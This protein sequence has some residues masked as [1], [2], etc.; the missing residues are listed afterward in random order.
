MFETNEIKEVL[1]KWFRDEEFG[2]E[3]SDFVEEEY[4]DLLKKALISREDLNFL[5]YD[6]K[7]TLSTDWEGDNYHARRNTFLTDCAD[8][9][10]TRFLKIPA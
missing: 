3:V 8:D 10:A 7:C 1:E 9:I 4:G 6:I 2:E 5:V